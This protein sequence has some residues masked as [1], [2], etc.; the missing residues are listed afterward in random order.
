[1]MPL[2]LADRILSYRKPGERRG[3][4]RAD[5]PRPGEGAA[6]ADVSPRAS[7]SDGARMR[8]LFGEVAREWCGVVEAAGDLRKALAWSAD[9]ERALGAGAIREPIEGPAAGAGNRIEQ[10][11][12]LG[13]MR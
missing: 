3:A 6:S 8:V 13:E 4:P 2:S 12:G 11:P 9:L 5:A 10:P 7:E 1:M